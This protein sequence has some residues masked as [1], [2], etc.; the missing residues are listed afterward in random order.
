MIEKYSKP[1]RYGDRWRVNTQQ[2]GKQ[3]YIE[4]ESEEE[5]YNW[6]KELEE[7]RE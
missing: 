2:D 6:I 3:R 5:A 1:Y 4:F 7:R